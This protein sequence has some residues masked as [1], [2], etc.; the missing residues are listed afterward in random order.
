MVEGSPLSYQEGPWWDKGETEGT[1]SRPRTY[2]SGPWA[3]ERR[4]TP[5]G[6][7]RE[8]VCEHQ[9]PSGPR[10]AWGHTRSRR[11]EDRKR[12]RHGGGGRWVRRFCVNG[13]PSVRLGG[14]RLPNSRSRRTESLSRVDPILV[15]KRVSYCGHPSGPVQPYRNRVPSLLLRQGP[16]LSP[17]PLNER[18]PS[19][20][21][22]RVKGVEILPPRES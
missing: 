22:L 10:S 21:S 3:P 19:S 1:P 4:S 14:T 7:E 5:E 20:V 8:G 17:F 6:R 15:C 13:G 2:N 18:F 16:V 12:V 11:E 9:G